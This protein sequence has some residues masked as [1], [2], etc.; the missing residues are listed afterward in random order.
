MSRRDLTV[1]RLVAR[2]WSAASALFLALFFV[3]HLEWFADPDHLPPARIF[4]A[5]GFHLLLI[6]GLVAA[7]RWEAGGALLTA[8]AAIG[9]V[10]AAHG[11]WRFI[12][13]IALAAGP[14]ALFALA[15][16]R[17]SHRE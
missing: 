17:R 9:F 12:T 2:A 10:V 6:S 5:Q 15:A 13:V 8:I 1:L 16:W 4:A 7:W 14:A 3:E 11:N